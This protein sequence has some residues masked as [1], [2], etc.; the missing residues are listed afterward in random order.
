ME[1]QPCCIATSFVLITWTDLYSGSSSLWSVSSRRP[2]LL[3]GLAAGLGRPLDAGP[4]R[5][6]AAAGPGRPPVAASCSRIFRLGFLFRLPSTTGKKKLLKIRSG[7][8]WNY[9]MLNFTTMNRATL[10]KSYIIPHPH[11]DQTTQDLDQSDKN[12]LNPDQFDKIEQEL[13]QLTKMN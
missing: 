3:T 10:V 4:A 7:N 5:P 9:N 11:F 13:D 6:P 1:P 8:M 2:V 12:L